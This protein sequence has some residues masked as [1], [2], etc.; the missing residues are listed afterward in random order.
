M[1]RHMV[2]IRRGV[3]LTLV[4]ALLA[5]CSALPDVFP[6]RATTAPAPEC[7]RSPLTDM[8][9]TERNPVIVAK[10][11]DVAEARPQFNLN[12]ADIVIVEQV[13]GGLTRL[14]AVY[15]SKSPQYIGPIRSAR[16]TDTDLVPAFGTPGFAYSG[17]A[18]RLVPY[19]QA[20]QMQLIGAP[21]G[22]DGY[23]RIDDRAA[24]HNYLAELAVLRTRISDTATS[25]VGNIQPWNITAKPAP[26]QGETVTEVAVRWPAA[27]KSYTWDGQRWQ[28]TASGEPLRSQLDLLGRTESVT[29]QN[30]V[31]MQTGLKE[32]DFKDKFGA[33]TPYSNTIGAGDGYVLTQGRIVPATWQRAAT[34]DLPRW[35]TSSGAEIT[36][37]R[38]RTW[39]LIVS[40]L[41]GVTYR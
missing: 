18:S 11:D 38:G 25:A 41:E 35:F 14:F 29:A 19:L 16:I 30:I 12:A 7:W 39:W 34:S 15:Q 32:S 37:T 27:K 2:R 6:K 1:L 31:I 8:C 21:Q 3:L 10:I 24:P 22:G 33:P 26:V 13:E 9:G 5:A 28:M 36:L 23:F 4:A 40:D 17:S 20:A